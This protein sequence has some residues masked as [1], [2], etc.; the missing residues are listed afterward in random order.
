MI[1]HMKALGVRFDVEK[2]DSENYGFASWKMFWHLVKPDAIKGASLF[3]GDTADSLAGKENVFCIAIQSDD[4]RMLATVRAYLS[5]S[6]EF[7]LVAANPMFAEGKGITS[8][9]LSE[10]GTIDSQGDLVGR[11]GSSRT[12]LGA[13]R[14][15]QKQVSEERP[16][17]IPTRRMPASARTQNLPQLSSFDELKDFLKTRFTTKEIDFVYWLTPEE[18]CDIVEEYS[19]LLEVKFVEGASAFSEDV[20][21][22]YLFGNDP[23]TG[24]GGLEFIGLFA[25]PSESDV[26]SF[27]KRTGSDPIIAKMGPSVANIQGKWHL[28]F[29]I[30]GEYAHRGSGDEKQND[31]PPAALWEKTCNRRRRLRIP[32]ANPEAA[33]P[34]VPSLK[35]VWWKFWK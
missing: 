12:A 30:F 11:A 16:I 35:R 6:T 27:W 26:S 8:E 9:P 25:F 20:A 24:M 4:L 1:P 31:I 33:I 7:A 2:L 22:V 18:L 14:L 10:A 21:G 29:K 32:E 15:E 19:K 28:N 13:V 34:K 23:P 17:D 5:E 3:E